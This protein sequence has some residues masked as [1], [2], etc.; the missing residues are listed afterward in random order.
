MLAGLRGAILL[1]AQRQ[2]EM[3]A[4][5]TTLFQRGDKSATPSKAPRGK[6]SS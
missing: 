1:I 4:D 5:L 3:I 2:L 6:A